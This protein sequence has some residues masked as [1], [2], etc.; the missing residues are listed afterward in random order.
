MAEREEQDGQQRA[1][2]SAK[3][4]GIGF[5]KTGTTTLAVCLE[6]LG[7]RHTTASLELLRAVMAGR[8]SELFAVA[9][10]FDSFE[11]WPWP[12]ACR[13]LDARYLG[14]RFILSR[15]GNAAAW[16]DSLDAMARRNSPTEIRQ[17][18]FG[19]TMTAAALEVFMAAYDAHNAAVRAH[20][21]NRPDD[22]LEVCWEEGD[23]WW[24]LCDFLGEA[25]PHIPF[26][27][28][29]ARRPTV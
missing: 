26:P 29:N 11:D 28:A 19:H 2:S 7:R 20:F 3:V 6:R 23:G 4:F 18:I 12:L 5:N 22:L 24:E 14:S 1:E 16:F 13:K 15:R 10:Q 25:V 17:L 21:R 27:H 9:D 8:F